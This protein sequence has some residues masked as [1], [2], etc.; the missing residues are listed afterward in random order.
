M[1]SISAL[2]CEEPVGPVSTDLPRGPRIWLMQH[3]GKV[4]ASPY[5]KTCGGV[6]LLCTP[7]LLCSLFQLSGLQE[8]QWVGSLAAPARYQV[9]M[10]IW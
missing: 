4:D 3:L 2:V 1:G 8:M 7:Q 5:G 9:S 10:H 6:A